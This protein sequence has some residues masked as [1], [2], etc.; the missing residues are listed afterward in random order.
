VHR[1]TIRHYLELGLLP[2]PR[3][4]GPKLHLFGPRHV[5]RL[6]AIRRLVTR[7]ASLDQARRQLGP[8]V[9]LDESPAPRAGAEAL[10][11]AAAKRFMQFGYEG[12]RIDDVARDAGVG[13]A[14]L[15]RHFDSKADL[16]VACLDHLRYAAVPREV[17]ATL[18]VGVPFLGEVEMRARAVLDAFGSYRMMTALL[19]SAA[20]GSEERLARRARAALHEM[21]T[22]AEPTVRRAIAAGQCRRAD[23]ELLAYLCWGALM[24]VGDR[25]MLDAKY[26]REEAVRAYLDFVAAATAPTTV[27]SSKLR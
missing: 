21:V 9:A 3:V 8:A 14:T 18:G 27:S 17:R 6:R 4:A 23:S 15:Y 11:A 26:R 19:A 7:G 22:N 12:V 20:T 1:S 24:A 13:K 5:T 16:F 2:A 10:I 25:L